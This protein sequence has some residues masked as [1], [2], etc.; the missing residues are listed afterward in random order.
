MYGYIQMTWASSHQPN[1]S[2]I[3]V[4]IVYH[5]TSPSSYP[6]PNMFSTV[7]MIFGPIRFAFQR[8][9]A[10]AAPSAPRSHTSP[11]FTPPPYSQ[12][13]AQ[14]YTD[15]YTAPS[16]VYTQ[17]DGDGGVPL[18]YV[19][20]STP[21]SHIHIEITTTVCDDVIALVRAFTYH[22]MMFS[23]CVCMNRMCST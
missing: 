2:P 10:P 16:L 18:E 20:V 5:H 6:K 7:A 19:W 14:P 15:P 22:V 13:S 4:H 11:I 3:R 23:V 17:C 1:V 21:P 9:V 12:P 8:S